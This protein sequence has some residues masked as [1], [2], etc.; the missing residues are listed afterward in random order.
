LNGRFG[1]GAGIAALIFRRHCWLFTP[2]GLRA[3]NGENTTGRDSTYPTPIPVQ[4]NPATAL[5]DCFC[6]I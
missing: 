2:L 5:E 4:T 1:G 3:S 6:V